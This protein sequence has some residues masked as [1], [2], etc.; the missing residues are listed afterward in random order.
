MS[1]TEKQIGED[2][3]IYHLPASLEQKRLWLL[4]QLSPKNLALRKQ[5]ALRLTGTLK[6]EILKKSLTEIVRRHET[7]R[8]TF[9]TIDGELAQFIHPSFV[10]DLE[11][12]SLWNVPESEREST[13]HECLRAYLREPIDLSKLPLIKCRLLQ[14]DQDLHILALSL[15]EIVCD[16]WSYGLLERELAMLYEAYA[17]NGPSTLPEPAVQFGDFAQWQSEWVKAA[18]FDGD[19]S[20]W[21]QQLQGK[22]PV[23]DLPMDRKAPSGLI[24]KAHT[25]T[26]SMGNGLVSLLRDFCKREQ[27]T[28]A[29]LL[30]AAFKAFLHRYTGQ[31][32]ILVG[33]PV[34]GRPPDT[35][36]ILGPFAY[37]VCLRTSL[38]GEPTFR[39]LLHRVARVKMD[40]LIHK[41]APFSCVIDQLAIEQVQSRNPLFQFYFEHD[42]T[43]EETRRT[44][45]LVWSPL[46]VIDAGTSFELHLTTREHGA[47]LAASLAYKPEMF[48]AATIRR[49]LV[50]LRGVLEAGVANPDIRIANIP[51]HGPGGLQLTECTWAK[52]SAQPADEKSIVDLFEEQV[53]LT[54]DAIAVSDEHQ[55][56]TYRELNGRANAL[57][58][59]LINPS[60]KPNKIVGICSGDSCDLVIGMLAVLKS[61][62]AY[63]RLSTPE[64][65][66]EEE[67]QCVHSSLKTVFVSERERKWFSK[68]GVR[69]LLFGKSGTNEPAAPALGARPNDRPE[70]SACVRFATGPAVEPIAVAIGNAA[71]MARA[72]AIGSV[73]GLESADRV[74]IDAGGSAEEGIWSCLISGAAI[75]FVPAQI[76][77]SSPGVWEFILDQECHV[78]LLSESQLT[79]S[80]LS[81]D[82]HQH[83][84][85]DNLRLIVFQEEPLSSRHLRALEALS[86][87]AGVW[88]SSYGKPETGSMVALSGPLRP[89]DRHERGATVFLDYAAPGSGIRILNKSLRPVPLGVYG[90]ICVCGSGVGQGYLNRPQLTAARFATDPQDGAR[91]FRSGDLGRLMPDGRIE[92]LGPPERHLNIDGFRLHLEALEYALASHPSVAQAVAT[93]CQPA[94]KSR[95][96]NVYVVIDQEANK[97]STEGWRARLRR[98]LR[99][100]A[101]QQAPEYPAIAN[102]VFCSVLKRDSRGH[103]DLGALEQLAP[104]ASEEERSITSPRDNL[105]SQ[106]LSVWEEI[107]ADRPI[108]RHDNFFALGGH[109]ILAL[110]LFSRIQAVCKQTLPVST[111]SRG[112]TIEGL[113]RMLRTDH[114]LQMFSSLLPI[115]QSGQRPELYI[116]SGLAGN[117]IRFNDLA[118]LLH[119]DQPVYALQPPGLDG[120]RPYLTRIED[121]A[122]HYVSEIK[123]A[124]RH[125]PYFVMGYSFGALVT[126]EVGR[127]LLAQGEEVGLLALLD[128][129]QALHLSLERSTVNDGRIPAYPATVGRLLAGPR[130]PAY[131][132]DGIRRRVSKL[133]G[134]LYKTLGGPLAQRLTTVEEVNSTAAANY[135]PKPYNGRITL[136]RAMDN[137]APD[138]LDSDAGWR[139]LATGGLE[140]HEIP[141]SHDEIIAEPNVRTLACELQHC[142]DLAQLRVRE[143]PETERIHAE[144]RQGDKTAPPR[145]FARPSQ[146]RALNG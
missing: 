56:L 2:S 31:D 85:S 12:A 11:V 63:L 37:P 8:T 104:G 105:E 138:Q 42:A 18:Q 74:A 100:V 135:T 69:T 103:M 140:V 96:A 101:S 46:A 64:P 123:N 57:A 26:L 93:P 102:I 130:L 144:R 91:L 112:P 121:M 113:A 62:A 24:S 9:N 145:T 19:L 142:L 54:P 7:L 58:Q 52:R 92:F 83:L 116:T 86:S 99:S 131:L 117:I 27:A 136:F 4:G 133:T 141:G 25:E 124:Q 77:S 87:R 108:G 38:S 13:A 146:R 21:R 122:A 50:H 44:G 41:E 143:V 48:E 76:K 68:R 71:L 107:F 79:R 95:R 39:Q 89:S 97:S 34:D 20:Y 28:L 53:G 55:T 78:L 61:G 60:A 59:L 43:P 16:S 70:A 40:A 47:E 29:M 118:R 110:R 67:F 3:S 15:P 33:S 88:F 126:F 66:R 90:E 51:M 120:S 129:P 84:A 128:P 119:P 72:R 22:L 106:L 17:Q 35:E 134:Q 125:G 109:W 73:L 36:E 82:A 45:T 115:R 1:G 75:V 65:V 137:F 114:S 6:V 30:L 111:L 23:L 5:M 14:L 127:L 49:M 32:D 94:F 139:S 132:R 81:D 80:I 98:E 10:A